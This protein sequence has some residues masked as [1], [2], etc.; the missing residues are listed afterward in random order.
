MASAT[1]SH[2]ERR[3]SVRP[4]AEEGGDD[5]HD[6]RGLEALARAITNVVSTGSS[7]SVG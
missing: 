2:I 6:E 5:A 3:A 1:P 4:G 7:G